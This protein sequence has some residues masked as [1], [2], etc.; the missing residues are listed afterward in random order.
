MGILAFILLS[1]AVPLALM[2]RG[3]ATS[4]L[5][6]AFALVLT[7]GHLVWVAWS[8]I[9]ETGAVRAALSPG[10]F[11]DAPADYESKYV[12]KLSI[13]PPEVVVYLVF[14]PVAAVA[15]LQERLRPG[16]LRRTKLVLFWTGVAYIARLQF[17]S[18]ADTIGWWLWHLRD[19]GFTIS[20]VGYRVLDEA[21]GKRF[22]DFAMWNS[23]LI[24]FIMT[25]ILFLSLMG[26]VLWAF[27]K[28]MARA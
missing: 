19:E 2:L 14:F 24:V 4:T 23:F 26:I 5:L 20:S 22:D 6:I 3:A 9:D 12:R 7:S 25:L 17:A 8:M 13:H 18:W 28:Q 10:L 15:W 21:L 16:F 11:V 1:I 27:R